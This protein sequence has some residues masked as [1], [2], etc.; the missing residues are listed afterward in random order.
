MVV[1]GTGG[2]AATGGSVNDPNWGR[3]GNTT[4]QVEARGRG[5]ATQSIPRPELSGLAG[6]SLVP[7]LM[8]VLT[9]AQLAECNLRGVAFGD[10]AANVALNA[11]AGLA[12]G[13]TLLVLSASGKPLVAA[14]ATGTGI[15]LAAIG[16]GTA[17]ITTVYAG[18]EGM[19]AAGAA[20]DANEAQALL[21]KHQAINAKRMTPASLDALVQSFWNE[22]IDVSNEFGTLHN[23]ANVTLGTRKSLETQVE[24]ARTAQGAFNRSLPAIRAASAACAD[25]RANPAR[26]AGE[27]ER[28]AADTRRLASAAVTAFSEARALSTPCERNSASSARDAHRLGTRRLTETSASATAVRDM[29]RDATAFFPLVKAGRDAGTNAAKAIVD[30]EASLEE[31]QRIAGQLRTHVGAYREARSETLSKH[32][33]LAASVRALHDAFGPEPPAAIKTALERV[34]ASVAPAGPALSLDEMRRLAEA[35]DTEV[36]R[37]EGLLRTMRDTAVSLEPCPGIADVMPAELRSL[38]AR[39]VSEAVADERRATAAAQ[40]A[41]DVPKMVEAC[42]NEGPKSSNAGWFGTWNHDWGTL[43]LVERSDEATR[44][45]LSMESGLGPAIPCGA[46]DTVV[47][48][49]V[50]INSANWGMRAITAPVVGCVSS[51][52]LTGRF[53]NQNRLTAVE[54]A[55]GNIRA[56]HFRLTLVGSAGAD[57]QGRLWRWD[58]VLRRDLGGEQ[59]WSG[60]K[61]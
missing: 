58:Q 30:A 10:C 7:P 4:Q 20:L 5:G 18:I 28:G 3:A 44:N 14:L 12:V 61:R 1:R 21:E 36:S 45:A 6:M 43:T 29:A 26:L 42:L 59:V 11:A 46:S 8:V 13:K 51:G 47:T 40:A 33:R 50:T 49:E 35:A 57:F 54:A 2:G 15:G 52:T 48:G 32:S 39:V 34:A 17:V 31:A 41:A 23:S 53:S 16:V 25:S 9:A 56:G 27:A 19:N 60:R 55:T 22:S 38:F 24:K 37:I